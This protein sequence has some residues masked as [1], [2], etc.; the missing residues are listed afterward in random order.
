MMVVMVRMKVWV[1]LE[2]GLGLRGG[3]LLVNLSKTEL[4][5]SSQ[6]ERSES[7]L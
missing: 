6:K 4:F 5:T 3:V 1:G 7:S 2:F